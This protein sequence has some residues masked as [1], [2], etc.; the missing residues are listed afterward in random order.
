MIIT[1]SETQSWSNKH[2]GM[3]VEHRILFYKVYMYSGSFLSI[4]WKLN[5]EIR[6]IID[7]WSTDKKLL[8]ISL[9]L[10]LIGFSL[11]F[12]PNKKLGCDNILLIA[13]KIKVFFKKGGR[14]RGREG[15][16]GV[17]R[18]EEGKGGKGV[19]RDSSTALKVARYSEHC[20]EDQHPWRKILLIWQK[21]LMLSTFVRT[22]RHSLWAIP[23][24]RAFAEKSTAGFDRGFEIKMMDNLMAPLVEQLPMTIF[25][26]L[27]MSLLIMWI[28]A[29]L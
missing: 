5:L 24:A 6:K 16:E 18:G 4:F 21:I 2:K 15:R 3:A 29:G 8:V 20:Y 9:C 12:W 13:Y 19:D 26:P 14:V 7:Q 28:W 27:S 23:A 22:L 10:V 25:W 17:R 1:P 11:F